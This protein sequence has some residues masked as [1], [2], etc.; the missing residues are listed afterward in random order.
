MENVEKAKDSG[1]LCMPCAYS[2]G[3]VWPSGHRATFHSGQ[4]GVCHKIT[5]LAC[6]DDWDWPW[7]ELEQE[8]KRTRET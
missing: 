3:G 1:Y 4:C 2:L 7:T 8:A 5:S 6:W